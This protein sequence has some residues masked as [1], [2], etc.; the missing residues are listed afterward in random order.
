[1][2]SLAVVYGSQLRGIGLVND[3]VALVQGSPA[4]YGDHSGNAAGALDLNQDSIWTVPVAANP[5]P[6]AVFGSDW[7]PFT[8]VPPST[9]TYPGIMSPQPQYDVIRVDDTTSILTW[10][11]YAQNGDHA[12]C[13]LELMVVK[14]VGAGLEVGNRL[15]LF[16]VNDQPHVPAFTFYKPFDV[17]PSGTGTYYLM[18]QQ[19]V[20]FVQTPNRRVLDAVIEVSITGSTLAWVATH[21][22]W[23]EGGVSMVQAGGN[24]STPFWAGTPLPDGRVPVFNGID[25]D[26][27][28]NGVPGMFWLD[29]NLQFFVNNRQV[30]TP[31]AEQFRTK[32]VAGFSGVGGVP[33]WVNGRYAWCGWTS[34]IEVGIAAPPAVPAPAPADNHPANSTS[35]TFPTDTLPVPTTSVALWAQVAVPDSSDGRLGIMAGYQSSTGPTSMGTW[36]GAV[37]QFPTDG[38]APFLTSDWI[39]L[40]NEWR[41]GSWTTGQVRTMDAPTQ[42]RYLGN[43]INL[44]RLG[45]FYYAT[46]GDGAAAVSTEAGD[47]PLVCYGDAP[48]TIGAPPFAD[49]NS[50]QAGQASA[51]VHYRKV[52]V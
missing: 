15:R 42:F 6:G 33:Q 31:A 17:V 47:A 3:T 23:G 24:T 48:T 19:S 1:M 11:V 4:L 41:S 12:S 14:R 49:P 27:G 30:G 34:D 8:A 10:T 21:S 46:A 13:A 22:P 29:Q 9:A 7:G 38:R 52:T 50:L 44:I 26:T 35:L 28:F 43:G 40:A 25:G 45:R 5:S 39:A 16:E 2:A 20:F 32:I 37:A 36:L 51:R 18:A